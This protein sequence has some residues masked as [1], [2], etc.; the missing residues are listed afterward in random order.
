METKFLSGTESQEY[1][2]GEAVVRL[3]GETKARIYSQFSNAL[4]VKVFGKSM[5]YQFLHTH[6]LRMWKPIGKM[7]CVNLGR[8]YFLIRFA[9]KTDHD[10]VLRGG[11]WFVGGHFLAIKRWEPNF[12]P[13]RAFESLVAV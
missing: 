12:R 1:S 4:I 10:N 13:S 5:G 9:L 7:D 3:S 2:E 11:P 6:I 8:D